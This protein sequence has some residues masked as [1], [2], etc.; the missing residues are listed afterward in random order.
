MHNPKYGIIN[1]AD[2]VARDISFKPK[3]CPFGEECR[4]LKR[5]D[6]GFACVGAYL[7][8]DGDGFIEKIRLCVITSEEEPGEFDPSN[9]L[10]IGGYPFTMLD[11][12]ISI[13]EAYRDIADMWSDND[14]N[15]V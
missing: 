7:Y 10:S 15:D 13:M 1:K 14:D 12:A 4:A 3:W 6:E 11:W 9:C 8:D 5:C 2:I